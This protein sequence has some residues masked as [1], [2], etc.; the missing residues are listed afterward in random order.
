MAERLAGEGYLALAVDLYKGK[1]ATDP[2]EAGALMGQKD[3]K[4]GD[5]VEEAGLE[6]LK[7]NGGGGQGGALGGCMGGRGA[8][9]GSPP[10]PQDAAATALY[11]RTPG[12]HVGRR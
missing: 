12:T 4:W 9:Q 6:W 1:V 10:A 2:K 8:P 3:E 7:S 11:Y 5:A